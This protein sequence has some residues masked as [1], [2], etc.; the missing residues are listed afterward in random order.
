MDQNAFYERLS[1]NG[2]EYGESF[3]AVRSISHNSN[4]AVAHLRLPD[5][6]APEAD[7]FRA[8]PAILDAAFQTMLLVFPRDDDTFVPVS[9]RRYRLHRPLGSEVWCH[10]RAVRATPDERFADLTLVDRSGLILGE[11]R[12]LHLRKLETV[13]RAPLGHAVAWRMHGLSSADLVAAEQ[14]P[15]WWLVFADSLTGGRAL[16]STAEKALPSSG[17][18]PSP[19]TGSVGNCIAPN[20]VASVTRP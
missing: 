15:G 1:S 14:V 7:S 18:A 16:R 12:G 3:R 17:E 8:H 11:I 10:T 9:L 2:I 19:A 6:A 5:S 20:V 13:S 4:E